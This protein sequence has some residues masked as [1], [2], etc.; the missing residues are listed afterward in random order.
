MSVE[1]FEKVKTIVAENL[2]VNDPSSITADTT[3]KDDLDADSLDVVELVMKLEDEF[4]I[5]IPDEDA[6]SITKVGEA[7]DY[8]IN[9]SA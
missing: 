8:I 9:H 5:E 2:K 1:I 3:F 7:V 6:K 4:N